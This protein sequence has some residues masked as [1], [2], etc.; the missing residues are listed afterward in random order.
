MKLGEI[1]AKLLNY[2]ASED[3]DPVAEEAG[4][5]AESPG[6]PKKNWIWCVGDVEKR[7]TEGM[8]AQRKPGVVSAKYM[9]LELIYQ[10][11]T[12]LLVVFY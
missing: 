8:T 9:L 6:A 10:L 3:S 11:F 7:A 12:A 1:K 2:E 5:S 4:E